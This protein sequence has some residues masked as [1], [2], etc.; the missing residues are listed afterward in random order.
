MHKQNVLTHFCNVNQDTNEFLFK[1]GA[2]TEICLFDKW[3]A[4]TKDPLLVLNSLEVDLTEK[5]AWGTNFEIQVELLDTYKQVHKAMPASG[6]LITPQFEGYPISE[7]TEERLIPQ[8]G[9]PLGKIKL[10]GINYKISKLPNLAN[11]YL[12]SATQQEE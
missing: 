12:F 6:V 11:N 2:E 1:L 5:E 3:A 4:N 8:S 7:E 10:G 9:T